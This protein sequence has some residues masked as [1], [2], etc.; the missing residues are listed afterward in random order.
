V[1]KGIPR[2][3]VDLAPLVSIEVTGV[4]IPIANGEVQLGAVCKSP[5]HA[6]NDAD[7]TELLSFRNKSILAGDLNAKHQFWNSVVPNPSDVKLMNLLHI[8]KFEISAHCS[9]I[10]IQR[11]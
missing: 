9:L 8:N 10:A 7:I 1:R 3:N 5:G 2:N 11:E 6:W 4:C